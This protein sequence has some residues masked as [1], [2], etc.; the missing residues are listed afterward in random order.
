MTD[1]YCLKQA[2]FQINITEGIKDIRENHDLSDVTLV[3]ED[4]G[5]MLAHKII[6]AMSS[7]FFKKI[8]T[9]NS[10]NNSNPL[11]FLGGTRMT[12]VALLLEFIYNGTVIL[13]AINF[14]EFFELAKYLGIKG[15]ENHLESD[16]KTPKKAFKRAVTSEEM[17]AGTFV[18]SDDQISKLDLL[19]SSKMEKT[20]LKQKSWSPASQPPE[21]AKD[22]LPK[23]ARNEWKCKECG[24][25][26][27]KVTFN[28]FSFS[29][30]IYLKANIVTHVEG[31]HVSGYLHPCFMCGV[32]FR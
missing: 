27:M 25:T 19:I 31:R 14:K 16:R 11:I 17:F 24:K 7:T 9:E 32:S 30:D 12:T 13:D 23:N 3:V 22:E 4:G 10:E 21:A 6:L 26:G 8:L 28:L 15:L 2:N 1:Q 18:T 20:S 5:R 29:S